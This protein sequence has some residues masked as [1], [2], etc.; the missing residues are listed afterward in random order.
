MQHIRII[1]RNSKLA[2][3]QANHVK[4]ILSSHYPEISIEIIGVTTEGDRILD[5]SLDKIGGKGLFIKELETQLMMKSA[6]LA[7]HSLKD[8]PANLLP[9][10]DLAAVLP[11]ENPYDA[12]VSNQF[13]SLDA[14]PEGGVIGT[15]SA[16]RVAILKRYFPHLQVKLLRGN[17]QTRLAKLD[18]GDYDAI[19]LAVAGLKRLGLEER[20]TQIL[21]KETF[22][23][24]IGQGALAIEILK[25]N[26]ELFDLLQPLN[27]KLTFAAVSAERAMGRYLN[28]SCNIPIAG[29]AEINQDKLYLRGLIADSAD[30]IYLDVAA[31]GSID[32]FEQIGIKC[33]ENL[34]QNGAA[35]IVDKYSN[36]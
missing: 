19:I 29:Y 4:Q 6:D 1:S 22:I 15:S 18:N 34:L 7:V 26:H 35:Q 17:L 24:A 2:M 30:N 32:Q 8:L 23:P 33:A 28:A 16:R 10:F 27:D 12:L 14:I 5:K 13:T 11:R 36:N 25:D 20:I 31:H 9:E 3:W 21:P